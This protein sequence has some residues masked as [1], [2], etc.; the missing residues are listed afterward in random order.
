M[1]AEITVVVTTVV[2]GTAVA[3]EA[4]GTVVTT[5]ADAITVAVMAAEDAAMTGDGMDGA[6]AEVAAI[7]AAAGITG[8]GEVP[9]DGTEIPEKRSRM[10]SGKDMKPDS[11]MDSGKD[12]IRTTDLE[13]PGKEVDREEDRVFREM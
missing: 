8:A 9:A 7:M 10:D 12:G 4:V 6:A 11:V 5:A 3:A 2:A 13:D 1:D